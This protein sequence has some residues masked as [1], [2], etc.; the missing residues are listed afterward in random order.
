MNIKNVIRLTSIWVIERREYKGLLILFVLLSIAI[1]VIDDP[2]DVPELH[3]TDSSTSLLA[4]ICT[5]IVSIFFALDVVL[6]IIAFG[7]IVHSTSYMRN[8]LN[9]L[10]LVLGILGLIEISSSLTANNLK[11]LRTLRA[12]RVLRGIRRLPE[13]KV[14]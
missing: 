7:L 10:D 4:S 14:S 6:N 13:M 11:S 3:N 2:L 12:L 1:T 5:F 9:V 8:S